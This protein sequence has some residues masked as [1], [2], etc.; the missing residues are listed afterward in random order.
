M[1]KS[2]VRINFTCHIS[3]NVAM[4]TEL[5]LMLGFPPAGAMRS[6]LCFYFAVKLLAFLDTLQL[7]RAKY[8]DYPRNNWDLHVLTNWS[9]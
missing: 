6:L 1:S 8:Q 9:I 5:T 7:T 2:R 3:I 4:C